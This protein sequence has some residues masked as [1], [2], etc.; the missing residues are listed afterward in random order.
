[1]TRIT[2]CLLALAGMVC[3]ASANLSAQEISG[4]DVYKYCQSCHGARAEGGNDGQ[5]PR[6]AGLPQPYLER[7]LHAFKDLKRL[8]KPMIPIFKHVRFDAQVIETV[9]AYIAGMS[10]PS[11][12]LWPYKPSAEALNGYASRDE[13]K[14]AGRSAY[15]TQC[16]GCHGKQGEGGA[17]PDAPPLVKQYPAYLGKQ[18]A[19]FS[20]G[21]RPHAQAEIC[22]GLSTAEREAVIDHLV[23]LGK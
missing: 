19:D 23:D 21:Q 5:Y 10:E 20:S 14:T 13:F 2:A 8:N 7:Q 22:G 4:K 16:A 12:S 1:M 9:A 17:E 3:L 18:M 6:L 11:L 15:Q